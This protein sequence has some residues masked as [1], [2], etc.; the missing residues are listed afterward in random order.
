MPNTFQL[1]ASSTVGA[2]GASTVAFTSIPNTYTDLQLVISARTT[3]N[4]AVSQSIFMKM[5]ALTSSIYSQRAAEGNGASASSFTQS[6]VDN[7]VRLAI[8]NGSSST[9]STFSSSSIYI[10]NYAGAANKSV[11]VDTAAETNATTQYMNLIAYLVSSTA[12]ITDLTFTTETA[13][14]S[15]AQYSTFYLYGVKNA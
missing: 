4:P 8:A 1:I 9:S 3:A 14:V 2:G 12:A 5:N 6:G 15:F 13:A 7:A 10:P 11:S